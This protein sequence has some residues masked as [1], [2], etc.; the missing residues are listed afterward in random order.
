MRCSM[1]ALRGKHQ[2][3]ILAVNTGPDQN[4]K[5]W[6]RWARIKFEI[7]YSWLEKFAKTSRRN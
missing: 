4:D 7:S 5:V 3:E 2:C 1:V 6:K